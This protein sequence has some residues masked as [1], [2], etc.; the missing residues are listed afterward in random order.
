M[1]YIR[2]IYFLRH[3]Q[4]Q[5]PKGVPICLGKKDIPL[6][7]EGII[8]AE[9]L[10][11]YFSH[12]N[13]SYIYS[14]PL[15]RSKHTAEIIADKKLN[16]KIKNDFSEFNIGKW[17]GMSFAEIKEKYPLEY[18]K[19]G[20]DLEN[21]IVEG[22]ESMAA[23][24]IRAISELYKTMDESSGDILIVAH[25]GVNRTIISKILG[26]CIKESF[27]F[28]H[29]YGS[30]N[31]LTFDGETFDVLKIGASVSDLQNKLGEEQWEKLQYSALAKVEE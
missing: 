13:L 11:N 18:K 3:C 6:S 15:V 19:R 28:R 21:Y 2:K 22:G 20:E 23:C 9:K 29:E 10:K 7:E 17:D 8:E 5:L 25:A 12:I 30:I 26:I 16:V 31:I 1:D 4:P 14:S 27:S 24:Q